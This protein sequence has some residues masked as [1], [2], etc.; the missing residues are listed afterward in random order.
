ML[1]PGLRKTAEVTVYPFFTGLFM[2]GWLLLWP[3]FNFYRN[4]HRRHVV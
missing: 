1:S 3:F 2:I 4:F